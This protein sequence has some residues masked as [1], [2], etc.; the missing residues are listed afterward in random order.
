MMPLGAL[1]CAGTAPAG[2]AATARYA[3]QARACRDDYLFGECRK[4]LNQKH[5]CE[6]SLRPQVV[7][8]GRQ[9]K[10]VS[11]AVAV[12]KRGASGG[13]DRAYRSRFGVAS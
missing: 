9:A 13:A 1:L 7:S 12:D 4:H 10:R 3:D 6:P 5:S 2:G 11:A 8:G